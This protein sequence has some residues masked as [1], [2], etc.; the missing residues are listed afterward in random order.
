[1]KSVRIL[2]IDLDTFV[3]PVARFKKE[4]DPRLP[5]EEYSIPNIEIIEKLCDKWKISNSTP[6][7]P[8]EHHDQVISVVENLIYQK[9]LRPP[10]N[11]I[12]IDAH[13]D[14]WGHYSDLINFGNYMY[15]VVRKGW[16]EKIV[17]VY[18]D[19]EL[20]F[21]DC[22]YDYEKEEV[23]FDKY[24]VPINFVTFNE[25]RATE[26]PA[27]VFLCRSPSY[28]PKKADEIFEFIKNFG[29]VRNL[30]QLL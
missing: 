5:D 22:I 6:I 19:N 25:F 4:D 10:L 1:M 17:W 24:R 9:L 26:E 8:F 12:R 28:T 18:P 13:D 3:T 20:D 15:E 11:W 30:K 16:C 23:N 21:P 7:Y 2:D 29:E 27:F 14:F